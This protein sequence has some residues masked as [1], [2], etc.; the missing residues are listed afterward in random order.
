MKPLQR[1]VLLLGVSLLSVAALGC[2]SESSPQSV[3]PSPTALPPQTL[4]ASVTAVPSPTPP[5][6]TLSEALLSAADM[7]GRLQLGPFVGAHT[8]T[9]T[10]YCPFNLTSG[11]VDQASTLLTLPGTSIFVIETIYKLPGDA[12]AGLEAARQWINTCQ[13]VLEE[14]QLSDINSLEGTTQITSV[15]DGSVWADMYTFDIS[16]T[17]TTVVIQERAVVFQEGSFLVLIYYRGATGKLTYT[18]IME[19]N[20]LVLQADKKVAALATPP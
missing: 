19:I 15:G 2:D 7:P 18:E 10:G 9:V 17:P 6:A 4:P 1:S 5:P 3:S 11:V 12:S 14:K 20:T 16:S 8:F 13:P